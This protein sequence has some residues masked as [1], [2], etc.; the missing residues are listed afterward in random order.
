[1]PTPSNFGEW[2]AYLGVII[3]LLAFACAALRYVQVEK[4]KAR[5]ANFENFFQTVMRV[6]NADKSLLSQKAAIFELRH[7]PEYRE[8]ILRVCDDLEPYFGPGVRQEL[9]EEFEETAERLRSKWMLKKLQ[10]VE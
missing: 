3:P 9:A 6:H 10:P 4:A 8:F 1:M 5:Q 2:V 7:Y